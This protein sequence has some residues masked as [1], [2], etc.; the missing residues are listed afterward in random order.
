[1]HSSGGSMSTDR[2]RGNVVQATSNDTIANFEMYL[3]VDSSC[4]YLDFYVLENT[5]SDATDHSSWTIVYDSREY[6]TPSS[7]WDYYNSDTVDYQMTSGAYYAFLVG[8]ECSTAY[9]YTGGDSK[10]S[11]GFGTLD[12]SISYSSYTGINSFDVSDVGFYGATSSTVTTYDT[13]VNYHP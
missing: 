9:Y 1:A 13:T 5:T 11:V 8:W 2:L 4:S 3:D 10:S 7:S 6:F 12:L